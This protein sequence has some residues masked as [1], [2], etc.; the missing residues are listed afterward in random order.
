MVSPGLVDG[1]VGD[2]DRDILC[3]WRIV[4]SP[5][6]NGWGGEREVTAIHRGA[7]AGQL[8]F[9]WRCLESRFARVAASVTPV[10]G[11]T[12]RVLGDGSLSSPQ[13]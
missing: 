1:V 2:R 3:G 9:E 7:R 12:S 4:R 5:T 10:R 6:Q 13:T 8:D 11:W